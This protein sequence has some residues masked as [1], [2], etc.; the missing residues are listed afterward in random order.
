MSISVKKIIGAV[1]PALAKALGGPLAGTAVAAIA[2]KVLGK[3]AATEDEVA[4]ALEN[5][6]PEQLIQLKK[7][8]LEF[9]A[10]L[11]EAGISLD[12]LEVEDRAS[13]RAM[14]TAAPKDW[15]PNVLAMSLLS[16]LIALSWFLLQREVPGGNKEIIINLMGVL[17][18][19]L[20]TVFT[21]F[22]GSSRSSD[23]KGKVLGRI[24]EGE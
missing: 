23:E 5:A 2:K 3:D 16:G 14:R 18:G 22:F 24:A 11:A 20:V 21:F 9:A 4:L 1:A 17:E 10:Q 19:A 15:V 12:R 13:A 8:D 7:L 6:T